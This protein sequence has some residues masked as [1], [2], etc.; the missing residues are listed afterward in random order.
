[1]KEGLSKI[2]KLKPE[3]VERFFTGKPCIVKKDVQ[4][5][6]AQKIKD[7]FDKAGAKCKLRS[8]RDSATYT[9]EEKDFEDTSTIIL[10]MVADFI[11]CPKCGLAQEN[12]G[13]CSE[14]GLIF[15]KYLKKTDKSPRVFDLP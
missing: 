6:T 7:G 5:E 11:E 3:A 1:V 4:A 12:L 15:D 13:E 14:C 8:Y 2:F 9:P 10:E